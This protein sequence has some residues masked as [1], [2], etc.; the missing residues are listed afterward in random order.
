LALTVFEKTLDGVPIPGL[1][2]LIAGILELAKTE[3]VSML[4]SD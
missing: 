1:K 4:D 3:E 2:G